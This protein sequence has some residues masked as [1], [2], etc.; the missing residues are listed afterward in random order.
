MKLLKELKQA[1]EAQAEAM[2]KLQA[3][4]RKRELDDL[5]SVF[6]SN[7]RSNSECAALKEDCMKFYKLRTS[8]S[9][10][11]CMIL[12][13][14]YGISDLKLAHIWPHRMLGRHLDKFGLSEEDVNNERNTMLLAPAIEEAFDKRRICFIY[15]PIAA[16]IQLKVL[17]PELLK[18]TTTIEPSG[19]QTT[20]LQWKDINGTSSLLLIYS[21]LP[22]CTTATSRRQDTIP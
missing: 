16:K 1:S 19:P 5:E 11:K 15:N 12:N 22:R 6:D 13:R 7:K 14:E 3:N 4:T 10:A 17:D 20:G 2:K 21:N 18:Y 9:K 8:E